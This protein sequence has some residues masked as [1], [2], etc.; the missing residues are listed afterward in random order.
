MYDCISALC[1]VGA[2][3]GYAALLFVFNVPSV[4]PTAAKLSARLS[5]LMIPQGS[6]L[7][8]LSPIIKKAASVLPSSP[9]SKAHSKCIDPLAGFFQRFPSK[10]GNVSYCQ[11]VFQMI[12]LAIWPNKSL[13]AVAIFFF[14]ASLLSWSYIVADAVQGPMRKWWNAQSWSVLLFAASVVALATSAFEWASTPAMMISPRGRGGNFTMPSGTVFVDNV[15]RAVDVEL[16]W[17]SGDFPNRTIINPNI[18]RFGNSLVVAARAHAKKIHVGAGQHEDIPVS[19]IRH[20]WM[21]DIV[22]ATI[23]DVNLVGWNP[24]M[25]RFASD[26]V[27]QKANMTPNRATRSD[28]ENLC[29][30]KPNYIPENET[31]VIKEVS[32]PEDPKLFLHPGGSTF[33]MSFSSYPPKEVV[34]ECEQ[35]PRGFHQMFVCD[36][37]A[38]L[39]SGA[40]PAS[41]V[42]L[43]Y[44][45]RARNEKN[46]IAFTLQDQLY[47]VYSIYPHTII[48][49]R[50]Q[51]GAAERVHVTSDFSPM[52]K[53]L[54]SNTNLRLHGS[55]TAVRYGDDFLGIFHVLDT[56]TYDYST[57]AYK[58]RAKPPF[59]VIAM[60]N[61]PLP[62]QGSARAFAS[63]LQVFDDKVIV[64]YGVKNAQSRALVMSKAFLDS[65]FEHCE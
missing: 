59:N 40:R 43:Q 13:S 8:G 61:R 10:V 14:F 4:R 18:L 52:Q 2:I 17:T 32:G 7:L 39:V 64:A 44:G 1:K 15:T 34:A 55:A 46:W 54:S 12:F 33:G 41:A 60:S 45:F 5:V 65:F 53:L 38:S 11:Y 30:P 19:T 22:V 23:G 28:F 47:Y 24:S 58:F 20:Q 50:A 49:A 31:L 25:W 6:I 57:L 3:L 9:T 42:R 37:G 16:E 63:G 35:K 62:L 26:V 48:A 51:D 56:R 21:S 29:T 36:D 27:L